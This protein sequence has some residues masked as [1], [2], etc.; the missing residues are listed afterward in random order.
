MSLEALFACVGAFTVAAI[1]VGIASILVSYA[2]T[3]WSRFSARSWYKRGRRDEQ[4]G[5]P[6][7]FEKQPRPSWRWR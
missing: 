7:C 5:Y 2:H 1:G 4:A 6:D 3:M